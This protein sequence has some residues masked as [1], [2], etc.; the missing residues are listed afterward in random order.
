MAKATERSLAEAL[1]EEQYASLTRMFQVR[2][3]YGHSLGV[4]DAQAIN[5]VP[6]PAAWRGRKYVLAR[7]EVESFLQSLSEAYDGVVRLLEATSSRRAS[8]RST[9]PR[10]PSRGNRRPPQEQRREHDG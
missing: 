4:V 9:A 10:Q 5:K 6:G 2:H 3:V 7:R 8:Q 1:G